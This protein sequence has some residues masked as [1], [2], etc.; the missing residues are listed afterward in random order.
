MIEN[1]ETH[2]LSQEEIIALASRTAIKVFNEQIEEAAKNRRKRL[3]Y[4]TKKLLKEY[5]RLHEHIDNAVVSIVDMNPNEFKAVL[6][7]TFDRRGH[8]KVA[9][10]RQSREKT[11]VMLAHVNTMLLAYRQSCEAKGD[12]A[13]EVIWRVYVKREDMGDTANRIGVSQ[14]TAERLASRGISELSIL[15]W[16]VGNLAECCR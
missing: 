8:I 4:N 11:I 7:D 12:K 3:L 13:F 1:Q 2:V 14:R 16:G 6:T 9:A 10:I 5:D 15:L